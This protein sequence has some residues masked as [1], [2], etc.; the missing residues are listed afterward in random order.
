[1]FIHALKCQRTKLLKMDY[2]WLSRG[3]KVFLL[4][5][6]VR[7][8]FGNVGTKSKVVNRGAQH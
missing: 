3:S 7:R 2:P 4:I 1:M 8:G 5:G 6:W